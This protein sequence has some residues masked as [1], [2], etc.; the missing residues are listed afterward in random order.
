MKNTRKILVALLVVV[1]LLMSMAVVASAVATTQDTVIYLTPNAN[2]KQDN[3]RFAFYSWDGGDKWIDMTDDDGDGIYECTI[4][5]G[6]ENII[7]CRMNPATTENNWGNKWSQTADLKYDGTNNHYTVTEGTWD[8]GTWSVFIS[9]AH[10]HTPTDEGTVVKEATCTENG[11][12]KHVC[13]AADCG[14]EYTVAILA[15]GHNYGTDFV[16]TNEGC[17]RQ[18]TYT[19]VG[20]LA[21]G[22]TIDNVNQLM[23][24]ADGVYTKVYTDVAAG[25]HEYKIVRDGDWGD[26]E[27]P[28]SGNTSVTVE[29]AGSTVTVTY[30]GT[31]AT[32]TVEGPT[33]THV[34]VEGVCTE[35]GA[36]EPVV[37][38]P[39]YIAAGDVM[40]TN[41]VYASGTNFFGSVWNGTDENN[42]L[43]YDEELGCYAK[44]YTDVAAGEYHF[45]V[46]E[47]DNWI[48]DNGNNCY[49][50]VDADG[51]TVT[52]LFKDGVPS[53]TVEAPEIPDNGGNETP[54][55]DGEETPDNGG[56][57]TPDDDGNETPDNGGDE[58][59]DETPDEEPAEELN[60]FQKIWRAIVTFFK[61][62][63]GGL[64][65]GSKE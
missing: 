56:N 35:C 33:H 14:E 9:G 64:F 55:D 47:G 42:K 32:A 34:Y 19:V 28:A 6:I 1:S 36:E 54:D 38:E 22:W 12:L 43:V 29:T 50:K 26:G 3:A 63:F 48:G 13:S 52:I 4:P 20:P 30:N 8:K 46:V 45:K 41:D 10:I 44:V 31:E 18:A 11:E 49:I 58:T 61:S 51:S 40:M 59:P 24:Y 2:W 25:K 27:Y 62:I 57:E 53:S 37:T 39:V 15:T 7:L 17:A 60:F 21:G 65:G 16:C 23:T 5:A